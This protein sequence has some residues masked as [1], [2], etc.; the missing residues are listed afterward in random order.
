[1]TYIEARVT[2]AG[3]ADL[4]PN[5]DSYGAHAIEPT[6]IGRSLRLLDAME[7][8]GV[9]VPWVVPTSDGGI[10]FEWGTG[11]EDESTVYIPPLRER[12]A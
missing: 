11:T 5:W 10:V 12:S 7:A 6:C 3:F 2:V 9:L 1:M 8:A 4:P